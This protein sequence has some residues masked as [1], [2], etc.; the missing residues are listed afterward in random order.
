MKNITYKGFN[1]GF[2]EEGSVSYGHGMRVFV[3]ISE[4]ES[5][6]YTNLDNAKA[7]IDCWELAVEQA[8]LR[9]L[10]QTR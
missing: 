10:E 1:I 2:C 7:A 4:Y 8:Y 9:H 5:E 6:Y 3:D